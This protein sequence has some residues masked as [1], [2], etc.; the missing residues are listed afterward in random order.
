MKEGLKI[1]F[2]MVCAFALWCVVFRATYE[3]IA[4]SKDPKRSLPMPSFRPLSPYP[5]TSEFPSDLVRPTVDPNLV[6]PPD[7]VKVDNFCID[8]YEFPN[9]AGVMP[10]NYVTFYVAQADCAKLGKRLCGEEEWVRACDGSP[11]GAQL[12]RFGYGDSFILENC[13]VQNTV[14]VES[15][16]FP[17][18]RTAWG[19]YDMV[20]NMY[21]W[22]VPKQ[23]ST[24]YALGGAHG[25]GQGATCYKGSSYQPNYYQIH[26]GFRC[27]K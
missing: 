22:V 3:P 7:M 27:C 13:N 26:I 11:E 12:R 15:G 20:G 23:G 16:K 17:K 5:V 21:E 9:K 6:C 25:E 24:I 14:P 1:A 19:A 8:L 2:V 4:P 10:K 18:C